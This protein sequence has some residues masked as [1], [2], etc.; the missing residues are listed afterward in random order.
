MGRGRRAGKDS[1][2][3][4]LVV[5][6]WFGSSSLREPHRCVWGGGGGEINKYVETL[7]L[8]IS[9]SC[10]LPAGLRK[11]G[12]LRDVLQRERDALVS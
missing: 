5:Y 1:L 8:G 9:E 3:P 2:G 10:A 6:Y 12:K 7:V 11:A 4:P